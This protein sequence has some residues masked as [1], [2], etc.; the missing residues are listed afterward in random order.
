MDTCI[1]NMCSAHQSP[2]YWREPTSKAMS[3]VSRSQ[4]QHH[5]L[6]IIIPIVI[7]SQFLFMRS[8]VSLAM[9]PLSLHFVE[10]SGIWRATPMIISD[11]ITRTRPKKIGMKKTNKLRSHTSFISKLSPY[12]LPNKP[13]RTKNI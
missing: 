3:Q 12:K 9:C 1:I 8:R 5:H 4:T 2:R 7:T 6:I 10:K 13:I 11:Q